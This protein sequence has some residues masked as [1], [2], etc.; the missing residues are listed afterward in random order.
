MVRGHAQEKG[1]R[2]LAPRP[3]QGVGRPWL[4]SLVQAQTD[5]VPRRFAPQARS[6]EQVRSICARF[7]SAIRPHLRARP[8][9]DEAWSLTPGIRVQTTKPLMRKPSA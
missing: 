7:P 6:A 5:L 2:T 1:L 8:C 3:A 4:G 9:P